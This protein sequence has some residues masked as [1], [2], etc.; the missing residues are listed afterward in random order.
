MAMATAFYPLTYND[1]WVTGLP[2]NDFILKEENLLPIDFKNDLTRLEK[3]ING[4]K[5]ILYAPTFRNAQS[6][7][8]YHFSSEEKS[9]LHSYL[10][11]NN[12]ILGIREHMADKAH[13]Y[14]QELKGECVINVGGNNFSNIEILY[15]KAD[16][17]I[18]DYS[19]CFI[20]FMLTGKPMISFAFD[21]E[22]YTKEERGLFYSLEFAFAGKICED[23]DSL[24]SQI[25]KVMSEE[26]YTISE[27]YQNKQKIFFDHLDA[28]NAKRVVDKVINN[29]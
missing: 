22:N 5:F 16:L 12:I 15:R 20:D 23:F 21:Y 17:L 27:S 13:S 14:S 24:F 8:Y 1:V 2:R 18:T 9:L 4:K 19:S 25:K 3:L 7:G 26:N 6:D 29:N 10:K 28:E 11:K